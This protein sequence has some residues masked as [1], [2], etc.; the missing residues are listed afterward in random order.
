MGW[1]RGQ[2]VTASLENSSTLKPDVM[3]G[4]KKGP[5]LI[6]FERTHCA[7]V[8]AL[9]GFAEPTGLQ[10]FQVTKPTVRTASEA[11]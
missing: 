11:C 9:I 5:V 10:R 4:L 3:P 2:R 6:G 8:Y 1:S 7:Q